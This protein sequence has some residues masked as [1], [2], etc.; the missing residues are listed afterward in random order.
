[1]QITMRHLPAVPAGLLVEAIEVEPTGVVMTARP[2]ADGT[3]CPA[4]GVI[5]RRVHSHYWRTLADLPWHDRRVTWRLKV[6]RFR[7][8]S[9]KQRIFAERLPDIVARKGRR[10]G[11]LAKAQASIGLALGGEPGARLTSKLSM[12]VSGDTLLR[13]IRGLVPPA[14]PAPRVI[15]VDDWA[16]RRGRRYGTIVCDLERRRVIDLLPDR[17]AAPLRAWLIQRP[18]IAVVSR[19]RSGPYAE[20]ART[21]A[22]GAVQ[23]ADRWHLI[24][25]AS[26]ALRGVLDRHQAKL[27]EA[28][29]LCAARVG[30]PASP[31]PTQAHPVA[32]VPNT[33]R[34][35]RF[36]A[37]MRLHEQGV[38]IKQI[39]HRTGVARNAVRR[40]L[41]AGE[42]VPYRRAPAPGMLERHLAFVE[43]HWGAGQRNSAEIWRALQEHGFA[44]G[45]DVVRRWAKRRRGDEKL[46]PEVVLPSWRV[47]S[48]RRAARLLTSD[49]AALSGPDRLFVDTLREA[50]PEVRAA[51]DLINAFG[52]LIRG[53]DAGALDAWLEQAA[54][55]A[56]RGF[57]EGLRGD[58]GAVR[59]AI[60]EPWSNG[61]VEGHVNRLKLIKRQM[62]GRAKF[63]L[64]R[65]RVLCAA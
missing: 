12:P 27:R 19:D 47:P 46:G 22:P 51:A 13:M 18:S 56:L 16:W 7:C 15:G 36:E 28:A 20:A 21:G 33:R 11:R 31:S 17:S 2:L 5:T 57:A 44:G 37:V 40:W 8:G 26:N 42:A 49:P 9:C 34:Q 52:R 35:A 39:V 65:Q 50:A 53:D 32:T 30:T 4:C 3:S 58:H 48:S 24:V 41:R 43:E 63:D 62:F 59:A 25:N 14:Y 61:P 23:V 54:T 29:R 38:S 45:Y 60:T 6:R 55:T 10:T 64:L 1:M